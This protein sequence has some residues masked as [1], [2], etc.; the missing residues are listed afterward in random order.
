MRTLNRDKAIE[1]IQEAIK[2]GDNDLL[3][4]LYMSQKIGE[5]IEQIDI[6]KMWHGF[7]PVEELST[8]ALMALA[9]YLNFGCDS[10][11]Y[12]IVD[13]TG[14]VDEYLATIENQNTRYVTKTQLMNVV[15]RATDIY[16]KDLPEITPKE[17]EAIVDDMMTSISPATIKR[18]VLS[19]AAFC[20]WCLSNGKY[21]NGLNS[22]HRMQMP[23][24]EAWVATNLVKDDWHLL[25]IIN[26]SKAYDNQASYVLA[27]L[28]W[29]GFSRQSVLDMK[30]EDVNLSESTVMGVIIPDM[31]YE[32]FEKYINSEDSDPIAGTVGKYYQENLGYFLKRVV[33]GPSGN[34]FDSICLV[35]ALFAL[36]YSYENI[37]L[38]R[39]FYDAY[40]EEVRTKKPFELAQMAQK[41]GISEQ[42]AKVQMKTYEAYKSHFWGGAE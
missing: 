38:S 12:E 6:F 28:A 34:K 37:L 11:L 27:V 26:Q 7:K 20:K 32:F 8:E 13:C 22:F 30:D 15:R 18:C 23:A 39:C 10:S 35:K 36:G 3:Q 41:L 25:R 42:A 14:L 33:Y 1:L 40:Q 17:A 31:F 16:Q 24:P 19:A 21:P 9:D 4:S 2:T 5:T 29:M